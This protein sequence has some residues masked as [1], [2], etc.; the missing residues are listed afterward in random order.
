MNF[1]SSRNM[2][3]AKFYFKFSSTNSVA[4]IKLLDK[5]KS[6]RKFYKVAFTA[7]DKITI[8]EN[9]RITAFLLSRNEERLKNSYTEID[10]D[11]AFVDRNGYQGYWVT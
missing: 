9:L 4:T 2:Y 3:S 11:K 5:A 6:P 1:D 8:F 7:N 10:P